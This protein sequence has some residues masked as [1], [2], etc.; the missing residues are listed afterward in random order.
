MMRAIVGA[1]LL[2][3]RGFPPLPQAVIL[4][5]GDRIKKIGR[6]GDFPVPPIAEVLNLDGMFLLPGLIDAHIHLLGQRSMD[7]KDHVFVGEGLR[8]ARATAD[9]RGLLE[10]GFTT[11]RDCGSYTALALKQAVAEGSIPGPRII[12]VG[13]F[14]ERTGGADDAVFMPLEWAQRG[15]AYG[16]RLADGPDECRKAVREQI[17]DGADWIKT[18]STGAVMTQ[19]AT[20]PEISEWSMPELQAIIDEAHRL[21]ARVAVHAHAAKGIKEAIEAG[22]DTIE[23]GTYLDDEGC[24]MMVEHGISLVPTF[25]VLHQMVT[26]G[27]EYGVPEY[28]LRKARTVAGARDASFKRALEHGVHIAMGTDCAG[29]ALIPHGQNAMELELMVNAGMSAQDAILAATFNAARALG[30]EKEIGSVEVGKQADLIAVSENPLHQIASLQDVR[31]VMQ[32]GQVIVD[33]LD[34]AV[35]QNN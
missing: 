33:R 32:R 11:V 2:D 22:A 35:G 15:G 25:F 26:R 17:R 14:I 4:I 20:R 6:E 1:T 30:L 28:A 10:A 29:P 13:R 27:S 8:A 24:R 12:A 5:G 31:F 7:P 19:A 16:P 34:A 21:G 23:H 9:L 3:G 18:C